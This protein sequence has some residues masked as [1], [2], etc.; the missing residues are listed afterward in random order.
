MANEENKGLIPSG[1]ALK[2]KPLRLKIQSRVDLPIG[3]SNQDFGA[4]LDHPVEINAK[5]YPL[6]GW[7]GTRDKSMPVVAEYSENPEKASDGV[8]DK[9][10]LRVF[11]EH[12]GGLIEIAVAFKR[13]GANDAKKVF[14]SGQTNTNPAHDLVFWPVEAHG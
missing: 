8:K 1:E 10:S 11:A 13:V 3:T 6:S 2:G 5:T 7:M 9:P 4:L 14:H 12:A